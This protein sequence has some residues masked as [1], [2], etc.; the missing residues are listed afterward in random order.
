METQENTM[1]VDNPFV[2][3]Q[4][5]PRRSARVSASRD[6][7][8]TANEHADAARSPADDRNTDP[9][10]GTSEHSMGQIKNSDPPHQESD[11][12]LIHISE[13]TRPY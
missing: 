6:A 13:P 5:L 11:L 10:D 2:Q 3:D 1:V 12:S 7:C 8:T 9:D 4:P